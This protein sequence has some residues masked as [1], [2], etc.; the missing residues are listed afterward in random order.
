MRAVVLYLAMTSRQE[1]S[2]ERASSAGVVGEGSAGIC[3]VHSSA[4]PA[5]AH[6]CVPVI[7]QSRRERRGGGDEEGMRR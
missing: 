7:V 2:G 4:A 1:A 5:H 3:Y 6:T